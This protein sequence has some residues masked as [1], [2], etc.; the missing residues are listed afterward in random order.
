MLTKF[1][2]TSVV[3]LAFLTPI[4]VS[5]L[6]TS[7][8]ACETDAN[9][10]LGA[11][12]DVIGVCNSDTAQT[13]CQNA[14]ETMIGVYER[15]VQDSAPGQNCPT[16]CSSLTIVGGVVHKAWAKMMHW[17]KSCSDRSDWECHQTSARAFEQSNAIPPLAL[18]ADGASA[19]KPPSKPRPEA[20]TNDHRW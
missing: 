4:S 11:V 18:C 7:A 9:N 10:L 14:W 12:Q 1:L 13:T 6:V 16:G 8:P 19:I 20:P 15:L 5:G 3:V 17:D 2:Q